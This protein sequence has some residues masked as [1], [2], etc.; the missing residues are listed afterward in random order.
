MLLFVF[1]TVRPEI[2]YSVGMLSRVMNYPTEDTVADAK[3]VVQYLYTYRHMGLRYARGEQAPIQGASDSDWGE[4][5]SISAYVFLMAAAAVSS[6]SKKQPT[7]ATASTEAEIYAASLAGLES[8]FLRVLYAELMGQEITI[9]VFVD[10]SGAV[11][12]ANDYISNSSV[13]HFSRRHLKIRELVEESIVAVKKI[14]TD[15]NY[16]DLL[17]KALGRRRFEKLRKMILNM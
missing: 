12:I 4:R 16:A 3:K 17:S 2:G 1:C 11:S 8:T 10:N 5:A 9:D 6:L 14:G 13:R 7:I 15:D